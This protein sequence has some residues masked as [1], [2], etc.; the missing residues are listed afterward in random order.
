MPKF[1]I[2]PGRPM[3]AGLR[4]AL[5]VLINNPASGYTTWV[6]AMPHSSATWRA[7][8][9]SPAF[10]PGGKYLL[11][12]STRHENP[13]LS[14]SEFNIAT[15]KMAGIY[16]ATLKHGAASP[17]APQSDEGVVTRTKTRTRTKK[18]TRARRTKGKKTARIRRNRSRSISP[19]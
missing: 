16:I 8:D 11:F 14:R 4:T 13:T 1:T 3:G 7:N 6:R 5:P 12:V 2:T 10:D 15:L 19:A 9:F 18:R 17:F